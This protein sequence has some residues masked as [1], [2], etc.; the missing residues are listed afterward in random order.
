M[1]RTKQTARRS[2]KRRRLLPALDEPPDADEADAARRRKVE[3]EAELVSISVRRRYAYRAGLELRLQQLRRT[4][5][6]LEAELAAVNAATHESQEPPT[7]SED[8]DDDEDGD[9]EE[10]EVV[11]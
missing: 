11:D 3:L 2:T 7:T 9:E 8:D 4:E 10:A 1:A 6:T 5:A